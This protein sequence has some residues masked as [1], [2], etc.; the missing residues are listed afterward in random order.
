MKKRAPPVPSFDVSH[1]TL[2][3]E[4]NKYK[5]ELE[6]F[7]AEITPK[8]EV[9]PK[10]PPEPPKPISLP[11]VEIAP[12]QKAKPKLDF[13]KIDQLFKS[14]QQKEQEKKEAPKVEKQQ[15]IIQ[16][17]KSLY[18][19]DREEYD[20]ARPNDYEELKKIKQKQLK[21]QQ[22]AEAESKKME[23]ETQPKT[24]E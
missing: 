2:K 16:S 6:S 23:L 8:T 9:R 1:G 15:Q 5:S 13:N 19:N 3:K 21:E 12:P 7:M 4:D 14:K 10:S 24:K 18:L 22:L 11:V 17:E 20:P